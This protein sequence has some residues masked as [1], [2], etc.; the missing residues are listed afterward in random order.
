MAGGAAQG[1]VGRGAGERDTGSAG[2]VVVVTDTSQ[3]R[4]GRRWTRED[5]GRLAF[6]R[7]RVA[8]VVPHWQGPRLVGVSSRS[9]GGWA[10]VTS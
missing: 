1:G 9:A 5:V 4:S 10:D 6:G 7:V 3:V 8:V 2:D